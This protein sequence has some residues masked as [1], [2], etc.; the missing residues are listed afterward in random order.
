MKQIIYGGKA[1]Y[2]TRTLDHGLEVIPTK[3][4][5]TNEIFYIA[6]GV[7]SLRVNPTP[8]QLKAIE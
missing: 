4:V 8:E 1:Y 2:V 7:P 5:D 3:E 6:Y